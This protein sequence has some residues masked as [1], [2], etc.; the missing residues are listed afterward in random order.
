MTNSERLKTK[1]LKVTR[2]HRVFGWSSATES[3]NSSSEEFSEEFGQPLYTW[4][5][6]RWGHH[7]INHCIPAFEGRLINLRNYPTSIIASFAF[8]NHLFF[9]LQ[10]YNK[11]R[12]YRATFFP[13]FSPFCFQQKQEKQEKQ[14]KFPKQRAKY[15]EGFAF[16]H[17]DFFCWKIWKYKKMREKKCTKRPSIRTALFAHRVESK[18]VFLQRQGLGEIDSSPQPF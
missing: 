15:L 14:D 12:S 16:Q 7:S 4:C 3:S 10:S 9:S 17:L 1:D 5:V 11:G 8:Y 13:I 18:C 6:L 2:L